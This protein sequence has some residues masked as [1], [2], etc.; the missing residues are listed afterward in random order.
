M[1]SGSPIPDYKNDISC[2]R[3]AD[4]SLITLAEEA[5]MTWSELLDILINMRETGHTS[6]DKP[7][8]ML[9]QDGSVYNLDIFESLSSGDVYFTSAILVFPD[10]HD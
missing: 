10:A 2:R 6:I 7:V 3:L 4:G 1:T 5:D 8:E 9:N